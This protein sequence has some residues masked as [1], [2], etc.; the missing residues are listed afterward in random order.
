VLV[1][2][3]I[4]R[5][6]QLIGPQWSGLLSTFPVTLL[7]VV[8]ILHHHYG[9][10]TV[11]TLLRELPFGLQAIVVFN[12]VV[13]KSFPF[14]GVGIGLLISYGIALV[15]LLI[16]ELKLRSL[17]IPVFSADADR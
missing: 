10:D 3:L 16:Y 5:I 12:F 13:A 11:F 2:L 1:V 8:A 7:P 4:T 9:A 14:L 6:A 15:Y 17:L